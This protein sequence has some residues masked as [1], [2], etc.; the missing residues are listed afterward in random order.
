VPRAVRHPNL[1]AGVDGCRGGWTV[2]LADAN[3]II[4]VRVLPTFAEVVALGCAAVAVDMPIGLLDHGPRACDVEARQRL[5]PR[6]SSVFPTPLRAMLHATTYA[7]AQAVAGLSKQ[8]YHLLPKIR[9][10]DA[11]MTLR[12]QRTIVEVHP[13]LCFSRLLGAPCRAPKRTPEGRAERRAGL[14]LDLDHPPAGAA[15]DDVLDACVLVETARR[16]A[17]GQVERLGDGAR[18]ARGLRCEIVL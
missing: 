11:V 2:A 6:R 7:E 16:L 10:V 8:A 5:G 15:W 4:D 3:S 17:G 1:V 12:R 14:D 18:D 13:E 9:E